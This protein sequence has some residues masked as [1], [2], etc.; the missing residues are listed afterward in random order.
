MTI[1]AALTALKNLM[2]SET[3]VAVGHYPPV[4]QVE[5]LPACIVRNASGR[6]GDRVGVGNKLMKT[7]ALAIVLVSRSFL[8][9]DYTNCEAIIEQVETMIFAYPTLSGNCYQLEYADFTGP[10]NIEWNGAPHL[11]IIFDFSIWYVSDP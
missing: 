4:E 3:N 1:S 6:M 5:E 8:Q 2:V 10:Q 7:R 9:T 11:G